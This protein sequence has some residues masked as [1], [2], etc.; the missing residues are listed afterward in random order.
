MPELKTQ[1]EHFEFM[2]HI[3][4]ISCCYTFKW[5]KNRS[6]DQTVG[7][8]PG[9][10]TPF[11]TPGLNMDHATIRPSRRSRCMESD[12][13]YC[14]GFVCRAALLQGENMDS[15]LQSFRFHKIKTT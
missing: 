10:H 7:K 12:L 1:E 5:L 3:A 6:P 13:D 8:I 14:A 11:L 9:D 2:E 4:R 15:L